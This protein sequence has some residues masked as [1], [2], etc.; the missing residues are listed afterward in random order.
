[1]TDSSKSTV[2]IVDKFTLIN[3]M[4]TDT[5]YKLIKSC[6]ALFSWHIH[7]IMQHIKCDSCFT[8]LWL[9]SFRVITLCK[10]IDCKNKG[11]IF[12]EMDSFKIILCFTFRL[13]FN[14]K[15]K[16]F[17]KILQSIRKNL[18]SKSQCELGVW[19]SIN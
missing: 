17:K 5:L 19:D 4:R 18:I 15:Q 14:S 12:T 16:Q 11:M 2:S 3:V 9:Y 8:Q 1:M 13:L 6:S 7:Y 10:K